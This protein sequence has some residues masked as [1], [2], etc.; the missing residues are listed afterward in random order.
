MLAVS[1]TMI[2]SLY[3]RASLD[4]QALQDHPELLVIR[5]VFCCVT[6]S[7]IDII[8]YLKMAK[9]PNTKASE[10]SVSQNLACGI[11]IP[12]LLCSLLLVPLTT[13]GL[14]LLRQTKSERL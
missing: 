6:N 9:C 11:A 14:F 3:S 1:G 13:S 10:A 8:D 7:I 4:N 2:I 5:L 12:R